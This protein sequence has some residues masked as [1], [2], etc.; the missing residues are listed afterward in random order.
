M[1]VIHLKVYYLIDYFNIFRENTP[2]P[3][4]KQPIPDADAKLTLFKDV[5]AMTSSAIESYLKS[6]V[7][8]A[9]RDLIYKRLN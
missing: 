2:D 5:T 9:F 4:N 1:Y 6:M 7:R 3:L 8:R